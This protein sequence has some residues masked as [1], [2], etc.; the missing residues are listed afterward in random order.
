MTYE[1]KVDASLALV[2]RIASS[3]WIA[4]QTFIFGDVEIGENVS[5]WPFASLRGDISGIRI[6]ANSNV[7]DGAV[8]H[9]SEIY[10]AIIGAWVTVG[11]KA[12]VHAC[13]IGDGCLIGMGAVVLDGAKV[14]TNCLIG[15]NTTIKAGM[16]I[17]PGSMVVGT[18]GKI[19]RTLGDEEQAGL[20][21][22]A[23]HYLT[24]S[25]RYRRLGV[26]TGPR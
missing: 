18:P 9:V 1:E 5:I 21:A 16:E 12:V 14:G 3:A 25:D 24:L 4:P 26:G 15:A 11:H 2:P 13:E 19:V 8:V 20:K 10:P 6:G 17:P 23:E 7:Q 22:W